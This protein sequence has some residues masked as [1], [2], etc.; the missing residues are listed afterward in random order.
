MDGSSIRCLKH[1]SVNINQENSL[2]QKTIDLT[3]EIII[4]RLKLLIYLPLHQN[5]EMNAE[6]IK[7]EVAK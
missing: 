1:L 2:K 4:N 3:V 7:H 5:L 6:I